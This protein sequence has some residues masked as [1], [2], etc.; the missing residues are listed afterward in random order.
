MVND[1][2]DSEKGLLLPIKGSFYTLSTQDSIYYGPC[3]TS[4]GIGQWV[5]HEG[6]IR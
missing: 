5:Y 3:Y 2:S 6:S 1:N 4:Y